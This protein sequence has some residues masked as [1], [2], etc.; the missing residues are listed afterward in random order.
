MG[1]GGGG[2]AKFSWIFAR[3]WGE[4]GRALFDECRDGF[5]FF[6]HTGHRLRSDLAPELHCQDGQDKGHYGK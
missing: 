4:N 3:Y 1:R 6:R 2:Q 5:V